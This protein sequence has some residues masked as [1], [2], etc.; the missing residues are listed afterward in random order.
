M[1]P[2][3]PT[4]GYLYSILL[5]KAKS[6][7]SPLFI[8]KCNIHNNSVSTPARLSLYFKQLGRDSELE[9]KT[10]LF[11]AVLIESLILIFLVLI[12]YDMNS[13]CQGQF[14]WKV[15]F[16]RASEPGGFTFSKF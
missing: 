14:T 8:N 11:E 5:K 13:R 1:K 6:L 15:Q 4:T 10:R 12:E 7:E 16:L 2:E 9:K 3:F